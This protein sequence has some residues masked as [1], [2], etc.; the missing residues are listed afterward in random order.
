[1]KKRMKTR[2]FIF[3][4]ALIIVFL[5]NAQFS[6]GNSITQLQN[7]Q[8]QIS[9]ANLK[10]SDEHT[11]NLGT[12]SYSSVTFAGPLNTA[13]FVNWSF[14]GSSATDGI[15]LLVMNS[16][17]YSILQSGSSNYQ[18]QKLA[19]D[20]TQGNGAWNVNYT[21]SWYLVY[22]NHNLSL[23]TTITT[24]INC[25]TRSI[26]III[27]TTITQWDNGTS[28]IITWTS[29]YLNSSELLNIALYKDGS[30]YDMIAQHVQNNGSYVWN[31]PSNLQTD[32][33]YQIFIEDSNNSAINNT[34][35]AFEIDSIKPDSFL[36]LTPTAF[37]YWLT[38]ETYT[39]TWTT[40]GNIP[41]VNIY[42]YD[43]STKVFSKLAG[44]V[45]NNGSYPWN[46]VEEITTGDG[47]YQ[48]YIED[49]N[50]TAINAYSEAFYIEYVA[51]TSSNNGGSIPG[52]NIGIL[53]LISI[54][55]IGIIATI[56]FKKPREL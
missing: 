17:N 2:L 36:I 13:Q 3:G 39:I 5:M 1:M 18:C 27:P 31:I 12:D 4:F 19:S 25:L 24:N 56:K 49:S 28:H 55:T 14:T 38:N 53:F 46:P 30:Y 32:S 35:V 51:P 54:A 37:S 40:T 22:Y 21:D 34:C 47:N 44:D 50:N 15:D 48:I 41:E 26:S 11:I 42:L 9:N 6:I 7:N 10:S 45:N 29:L 52:Y 33:K 8:N 43:P 23:T 20:V 16:G